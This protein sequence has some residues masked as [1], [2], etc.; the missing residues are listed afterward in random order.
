M[1][2]NGS[3]FGIVQEK[4]MQRSCMRPQS[5]AYSLKLLFLPSRIQMENQKILFFSFF[6][7]LDVLVPTLAQLEFPYLRRTDGGR[8]QVTGNDVITF[9]RKSTAGAFNS[10]AW[11]AKIKTKT[12]CRP[13][14]INFCKM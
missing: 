4:L 9:I 1:V 2:D 7:F 6:I 14:R 11:G 13:N 10:I 8:F 3:Y 12:G 5:V